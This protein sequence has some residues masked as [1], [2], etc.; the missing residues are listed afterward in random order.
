MKVV[1]RYNIY[2][3]M[4]L[5]AGLAYQLPLQSQDLND[6]SASNI[7]TTPIASEYTSGPLRFQADIL[8]VGTVDGTPYYID[9]YIDDNLEFSELVTNEAIGIV[10]GEV[11]PFFYD[12]DSFSPGTY[13]LRLVVDSKNDFLEANENNNTT[14]LI[15]TI[16]EP[17]V[18]TVCGNGIIE[19]GE[20]CDGSDIGSVTCIEGGS[21]SCSSTCGLIYQCNEA[22]IPTETT[23]I[24]TQINETPDEYLESERASVGNIDNGLIDRLRGKILLQVEER[25]EAWYLDSVSRKK[26]YLKDGPAAYQALRKFGLGITNNDLAKIPIGFE[27]RFSDS[28]SDGDGLADKLENALGTDPDNP[29]TDGDGFVDGAEVRNGYSPLSTGRLENDST[30][31]NNLKGKILLQVESRGEAWYIQPEDGKRYYM[32]D[33]DAAY[34]IMRFLSLGITNEDLRRI[35]VGILE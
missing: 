6:L 31:S 10:S 15:I 12:L 35:D 3:V 28:D 13:E 33:G 25:G 18:G 17:F 19:I 22:P 27:N 4:A 29:D 2:L 32:K 26:F 1:F 16:P 23:N 5:G 9:G 11:K 14:E 8:F 7:T 30:L 20:E 21:V 24:P 34:Q